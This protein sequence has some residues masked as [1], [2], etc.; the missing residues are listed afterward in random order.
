MLGS[1]DERE[2]AGNVTWALQGVTPIGLH[3]ASRTGWLRWTPTSDQAGLWLVNVT[4]TELPS[5]TQSTHRLK[6]NVTL[7]AIE[8]SG[9]LWLVPYDVAPP[10]RDQAGTLA[11]P[12][13]FEKLHIKFCK[14]APPGAYQIRFRGGVYIPGDGDDF[15]AVSCSGFNLSAVVDLQPWG[16]EMPVLKPMGPQ[17]AVTVTGSYVSVRGLTLDGTLDDFDY[18]SAMA[19]WWEESGP[20]NANAVTVKGHG[21]TFSENVVQNFAGSCLKTGKEADLFT[22]EDNI[23]FRCAWWSTKGTSGMSITDIDD[24]VPMP[25]GREGGTILRRNL[26]FAAE[27]RIISH[28]FSKGTTT[29]EIDE[30]TAL[31]IQINAGTNTKGYLV[32][33]NFFLHNGKGV[34]MRAA[35]IT[36]RRNTLY[37]NGY[38]VA[39]PGAAGLRTNEGFNLILEH[40]AVHSPPGHMAIFFKKGSGTTVTT[41]SNNLFH[42]ALTWDSTQCSQ[43]VSGNVF[44]SNELFQD[45]LALNFS[46]T[47]AYGTQ[48]AFGA[49]MA[50]LEKHQAYLTKIGYVVGPSGFDVGGASAEPYHHYVQPM[51]RKIVASA[52][53]GPGLE[54]YNASDALV[55]APASDAEWEAIRKIMVVFDNS[56]NPTGFQRYQLLFP[57]AATARFPVLA[58]SSPRHAGYVHCDLAHAKAG[59]DVQCQPVAA[60]GFAFSAW[61]GDCAASG[62]SSTCAL[63]DVTQ[64]KRVEVQFVSL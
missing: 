60:P 52:P 44:S 3:A 31:L 23:L 6:L 46:S 49:P 64:A 34:A 63:A 53:Q 24:V 20:M 15:G 43:N 29:M 22:A 50:L 32:E 13:T 8:P 21:V 5:G 57:E 54:H 1:G 40:N 11:Q 4:E 41:C 2:L 19:R 12:L 35:D 42:G 59:Q 14:N 18:T 30:G 33:D 26:V 37:E 62:T 7:G 9:I 55:P 45:P 25:P 10:P 61:G 56:S 39:P 47:A 58:S 16:N 28:V 36:M 51:Q 48:G 27:S 38:N 17:P